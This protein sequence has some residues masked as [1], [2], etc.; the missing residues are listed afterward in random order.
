MIRVGRIEYDKNYKQIIPKYD[1]FKTIIV[2][3]QSSAYGSLGPYCLKN[4]KGQLMENIYQGSKI[5]Q[6][7]PNSVQR[8]SRYD[9]TVIWEHPA[10]KHIDE[11]EK[12][13]EE[14]WN[15]R[16]KLFDNPYPVRYPVT[17]SHRSKC[18]G[19]IWNED[20]DGFGEEN[21]TEFPVTKLLNYVE[22]RKKVYVPVYCNLAKQDDKFTKLKEMLAER[23]N[24]LICEVDGPHQEDM[25]Y[26]K[27]K[28]NIKNDFIVS[29]TMLVN[30]KNIQIMVNDTKRPFGHG[31]CLALALLDK[32]DDWIY[33]T[34]ER[35][36]YLTFSINRK[37]LKTEKQFN[38]CI[39]KKDDDKDENEGDNNGEKYYIV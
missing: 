38:D 22:S 3:T 18:I 30:K 15:W 13:T 23:T 25:P 21:D 26:Y 29:N 31:Y 6:N 10:E 1:N 34:I 33:N 32:E 35:M 39:M 36:E 8:Y 19:A 27:E 5:Y 24:L 17:F 20:D 28:Y 12:P 14:Y 11:E 4:E 37:C 7:V 9:K 2:M 16:K